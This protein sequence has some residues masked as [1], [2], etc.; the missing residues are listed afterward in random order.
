MGDIGIFKTAQHMGNGIDLADIGQELIAQ[1]FTAGRPAYQPGYIHKFQKSRQDFSRFCQPCN[2]IQA[3]IRHRHTAGIRLNRAKRIIGSIRGCGF[4]QRIKQGG[5]AHIWQANNAAI[6]AHFLLHSRLVSCSR[7][8]GRA[9]QL[10]TQIRPYPCRSG[11]L[12][13]W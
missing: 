1:P 11:A 12:L 7:G 13:R 6:K 5:F 2:G 9:S 3:R 4:G 8:Q 10:W